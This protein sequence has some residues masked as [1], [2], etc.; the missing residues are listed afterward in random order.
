M[1]KIFQFK[2]K[3]LEFLPS[4]YSKK[5]KAFFI[6]SIVTLII[7]FL[8]GVL[9][10]NDQDLWKIYFNLINTFGLKQSLP[11]ITKPSKELEAK[12]EEDVDRAIEEYVKEEKHIRVSPVFQEFP[13][14][15]S[16]CYTEDCK[17]LGGEI[18]LCSPWVD[19]CDTKQTGTL[20]SSESGN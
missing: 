9:K 20:S 15:S 10:I 8:S 13:I 16:V 18:R 14:D 6:I 1:L 17:S 11:E 3:K 5:A 4:I 7:S 12:I 19:G 2:N